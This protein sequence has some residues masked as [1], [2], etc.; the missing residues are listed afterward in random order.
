MPAVLD[1]EPH[2]F[3]VREKV[4]V[5]MPFG[6]HLYGTQTESSDYDFKGVFVPTT[7]EA[8]LGKIRRRISLRPEK[9]SGE[10]NP[11][12]AV[13]WE[14]LSLH[15]FIALALEGQTVALD[16]LHAKPEVWITS[17]AA[18]E[19]LVENRQRFYTKNLKAFVGYARRQAAKYGI[20]GSRIDTA[21][22]IVEFLRFQGDLPVSSVLDPLLASGL[23]HV[24]ATDNPD[25][26]VE[27]LGKRLTALAKCSHYLTTFERYLSS[28]GERARQA[29]RNEGVDWKAMSHAMRAAMEVRAIL[30]HGGF[31]L[32]FS[33]TDAEFLRDIKCGRI[34]FVD[35]QKELEDSI[36][37][38]ERL[39]LIS[40][41]PEVPDRAWAERFILRQMNRQ[42]EVEE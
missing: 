8:L 14:I 21:K 2:L 18:W 10:K 19:E 6:S 33:K 35:V 42:E 27:I 30:D 4:L 31:D 3:G 1:Y 38:I 12:G 15:E 24:H 20:K 41:L 13:E 5:M 32:P 22:K 7:R 25:A 23:E 40:G 29:E 36:F 11:P 26:P 16:M 28:Y 39:A 9:P 17:S 34:P 37:W